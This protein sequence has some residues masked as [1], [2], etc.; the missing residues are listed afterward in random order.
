LDDC[1]GVFAEDI[2]IPGDILGIHA[3]HFWVEAWKMYDIRL[4]ERITEV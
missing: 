1:V 3:L 4:K 2:D